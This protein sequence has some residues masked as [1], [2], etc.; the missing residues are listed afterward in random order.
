ME[1]TPQAN[2]NYEFDWSDWL[3]AGE[4]IVSQT[5]TVTGMTLGT[6]SIGNN[7]RSVIAW[8]SGGTLNA[9]ATALCQITTNQSRTESRMMEFK[10]VNR[11]Q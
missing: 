11:T 9:T 1:K 2:L 7:N 5:V 4:T 10:I 8:F 6:T 3:A